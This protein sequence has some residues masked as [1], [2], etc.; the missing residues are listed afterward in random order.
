MKRYD[1]GIS[2]NVPNNTYMI[3]I[4]LIKYLSLIFV[5]ITLF[6]KLEHISRL[7]SYNFWGGVLE[8]FCEDG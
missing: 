3:S 4:F 5:L 7:C 2:K 1:T 6:L 8:P